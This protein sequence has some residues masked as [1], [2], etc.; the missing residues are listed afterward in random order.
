MLLWIAIK[1]FELTI[2]SSAGRMSL[3]IYI[4]HFTPLSL[5]HD[6]ESKYDWSLE[7]SASIVAVYTL[8]WI[9]ISALWMHYY[10]RAKLESIIKGLRKSLFS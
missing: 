10:P 1:R 6:F 5:M 4:V 7:A 8:A 3:T 2:L 9:P